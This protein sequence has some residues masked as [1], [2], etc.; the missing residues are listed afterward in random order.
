MYPIT[1]SYHFKRFPEESLQRYSRRAWFIA[2]QEPQTPSQFRQAVKWS[3][4]DASMAYDG[5]TYSEEVTDLISRMR[6]K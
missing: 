6:I 2:K 3:I 1:T 4:I 5:T